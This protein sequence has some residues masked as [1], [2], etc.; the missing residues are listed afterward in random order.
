VK[1]DL[2]GLYG[3]RNKVLQELKRTVTTREVHRLISTCQ[4]C[5]I[6]EINSFDH[7]VPKEEFPEF[8]VHPRNLFPS[9]S[10]CNGHKSDVWRTGD[11]RLF[12]NLYL[13]RLPSIQYLFV[14][15]TVRPTDIDTTFR[16]ENPGGID[17]DLFQRIA[18]HY[19]KLRLCVRFGENN[20][21]VI[22]PLKNALASS[23]NHLSL[24]E[25]VALAQDTARRNRRSF[26]FNYWKSILELVLLDSDEFLAICQ[27]EAAAP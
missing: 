17:A 4:N 15:V 16:V 13:D 19:E 6:G 12:L 14:D 11:R 8:S 18:Y 22:T 7:A 2:L 25:S 26:G 23:L 27:A 3:Y 10:I 5:T 21:K 1:A 20:D 9:C 24:D